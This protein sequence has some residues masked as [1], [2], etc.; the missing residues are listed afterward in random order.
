VAKR[1]LRGR[2]SRKQVWLAN[3]A[4]ILLAAV[5][6]FVGYYFNLKWTGFPEKEL[7]DWMEILVIP[8]A[9]GIGTVFLNHAATRREKA[10]ERRALEQALQRSLQWTEGAPAG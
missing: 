4:G 6:V 2:L 5:F 10:A 9:I 1:V 8:V 3:F 7:F